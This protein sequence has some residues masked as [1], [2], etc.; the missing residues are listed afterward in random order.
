MTLGDVPFLELWNL[1]GSAAW[2]FPEPEHVLPRLIK[3]HN[4]VVSEIK[5]HFYI[6]YFHY[7][8]IFSQCFLK[9][10]H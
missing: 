1:L 3:N 8:F 6:F 9:G 4:S 10:V 5:R 2:V 7:P